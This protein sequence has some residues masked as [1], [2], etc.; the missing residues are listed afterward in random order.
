[1]AVGEPALPA[2]PLGSHSESVKVV[3]R[4][5]PL[6][7]KE[8]QTADPRRGAVTCDPASVTVTV[9]PAS[10]SSPTR[11]SA[12]GA[13][14]QPKVFTFD[15]VFGP[16]TTQAELY[17][18]T[19]RT[20]VDGVL[21]GYNGTIVAYGQTG[22]GKTFSME[23]QREPPEL[24][25]I[26]PQSFEHIFATIAES[27]ATTKYLIRASY[28]E[29]YNEDIRDLLNPKT[30]ARLEIREQKPKDGSAR[31]ATGDDGPPPVYVKDLTSIVIKNIQEMEKL[32]AIGNKNRSIAST[33]MNDR[34]SR[35]HCIFTITIERSELPKS[36]EDDQTAPAQE[37]IRVGKLHLV[38][39]AGSERQD[40]THATGDR[41]K[42]A[43]KINLSLSVLGNVISALVEGGR[44]GHVPYRDS[45]L[46]RLLQDSLG[47]NSRTVML[48][49]VGPHH[50]SLDETLST[51]RYANRAKNIQN[52][53]HINQDPKDALIREFQEEIRRLKKQLEDAAVGVV[54]EVDGSVS[55][56]SATAT[57]GN[58]MTNPVSSHG[59]Q[60]FVERLAD[61]DASRA[62]VMQS[63]TK[64]QDEKDALLRALDEKAREL[65]AERLAR[66]ALAEKLHEMEGKLLVGGVSI[67]DKHQE[68]QQQLARHSAELEERKTRERQMRRELEERAEQTVQLEGSYASLQD[69]AA[70]KTKKL[71]QL[72]A[73][74]TRQKQEI[75]NVQELF[76]REREDLLEVVRSLARE[77]KLKMLV[78]DACMPEE[79][80]TFLEQNAVWREDLGVWTFKGIDLGEQGT[81]KRTSSRSKE[82][83]RRV[84]SSDQNASGRSSANTTAAPA[85]VPEE[86]HETE[87]YARIFDNVY[88]ST[89]N[90]A[91]E[92]Q[93]SKEAQQPT[94]APGINNVQKGVIAPQ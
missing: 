65:D 17:N 3:V 53:P 46:T 21:E 64:T 62:A 87:P 4:C 33:A 14:E 16:A 11:V 89:A 94:P 31:P 54:S 15:S 30:Q 7:E 18:A 37:I 56:G 50:S 60:D 57:D 67:L 38:D 61:I 1:M 42:E 82:G 91:K 39:L 32:M 26:I 43:N 24:R 92:R 85:T 83:S 58:G 59:D 23:G 47:G 34:S 63:T 90:V 22:T 35:S 44:N 71:K 69:E 29:V 5:R 81:A 84:S 40:K 76:S 48:A 51:L 27:S 75:R 41:L 86:G 72:W 36:S 55:D 20:I 2:T 78:L 13:V 74:L 45:K 49:T 52:K 66:S 19:A 12:S 80:L 8:A 70:A 73:V 6:S 28:L 9:T 10:P 77:L 93:E 79:E 88:L 68:Q 25:G